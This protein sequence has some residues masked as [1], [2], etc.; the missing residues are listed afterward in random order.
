MKAQNRFWPITLLAVAALA[1]RVSLLDAQGQVYNTQAREPSDTARTDG[2]IDSSIGVLVAQDYGKKDTVRFLNDNGSIWYKFTFY[3]DDSDGKWDYPNADFDPRAFHQD[4]FLLALDVIEVRG[5]L[6]TVVV[7]EKTGLR[8]RIKKARFLRLLTWDQYVLTA[9]SVTFNSVD[10]P[11]RVLPQPSARAIRFV[12]GT[13][14]LPEAV[15]GE[16]LKLKWGRE[17]AE[18]HGWI[19]WRSGGRLLVTMHPFA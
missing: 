11:V 1:G 16:W 8:K 15:Q 6:Y 4:Y 7:N 17:G 10:N 9:F 19:R 13:D 3:Y 12:R 5:N 14:Y 18:K 2:R